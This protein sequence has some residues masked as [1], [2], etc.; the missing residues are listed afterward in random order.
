[1]HSEGFAQVLSS[2]L[3]RAVSK[4]GGA[5][6]K[7]RIHFAK[8]GAAGVP[9]YPLQLRQSKSPGGLALHQGGT[10]TRSRQLGHGSLDTS[11][12]VPPLAAA[13]IAQCSELGK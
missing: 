5:K 9:E 8:L 2:L 1:M 6:V 3:N 12:P 4:A 11:R 7:N 10:R 13:T